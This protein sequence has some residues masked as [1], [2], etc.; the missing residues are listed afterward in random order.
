M[1]YDDIQN[2]I[3]WHYFY[4]TDSDGTYFIFPID[5]INFPNTLQSFTIDPKR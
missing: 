5:Y 1:E 4:G 3:L 2:M